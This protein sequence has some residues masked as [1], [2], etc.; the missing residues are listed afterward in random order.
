MPPHFRLGPTAVKNLSGS[1]CLEKQPFSHVFYAHSTR[2]RG[3]AGGRET[4]DA[5]IKQN[6]DK[7]T[8]HISWVR[9]VARQQTDDGIDCAKDLGN[10]VFSR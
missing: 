8:V 9:V 1:W 4:A 6:I 10:H 2:F 7:A 3:G 5:A